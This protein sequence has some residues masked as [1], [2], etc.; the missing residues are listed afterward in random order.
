MANSITT[1]TSYVP[2]LDEVYKLGSLTARLDSNEQLVT[3]NPNGKAIKIPKLSMQ[4][5]GAHTRGGNYVSGDVTLTF[6]EKTP[7][8]DRNRKFSVDA[9]D[10]L[11]T[12]GIAFGALSGEFLRTKVIPEVDAVRFQSYYAAALANSSAA[13]PASLT[14]GA[15]VKAA[16]RVA[17]TSLDDN[18]VPREGR[19]LYITST[20]L[21][22]VK[23]LALTESKEVLAEFSEVVVVPQSRFYTLITLYDGSTS[24]Q[25][26]GG[27]IKTASTGADINFLVVHPMSIIQALKHQAP[28]YIPAE[29]NQD[30]DN[31]VFA[32]RIYGINTYLDNKVKGIYGHAKAAA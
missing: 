19:I 27:Y 5:L 29:V 15:A 30:G 7:N 28:K 13:T 21:G 12:A 26:A 17:Q 8:Y 31:D 24:G 4:G 23:D 20:L 14:T 18:E 9:M 25:E 3:F 2:M 32:Y 22:L 11:E 10:D 1:M 6:E 16:L